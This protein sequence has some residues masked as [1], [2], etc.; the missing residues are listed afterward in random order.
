MADIVPYTS[1]DDY[2]ACYH[3]QLVTTHRSLNVSYTHLALGKTL[4]QCDSTRIPTIFVTYTSQMTKLNTTILL[5]LQSLPQLIRI[6]L[7]FT[8]SLEQKYPSTIFETITKYKN[9][10]LQSFFMLPLN[11][12]SRIILHTALTLEVKR[13]THDATRVAFQPSNLC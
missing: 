5:T 8:H 13:I 7:R 1:N 9:S 3:S 2:T 11:K 6:I 10:R 12:T 4:K